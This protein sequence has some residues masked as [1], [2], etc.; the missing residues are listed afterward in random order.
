MDK[1]VSKV[2]L[3]SFSP[4]RRDPRVMRQ[5]RLLE[6]MSELTVVGFGEAPDARADFVPIHKS[7][8]PLLRKLAWGLKLLF[9][10]HE[11][12]YW[13]QP[14]VAQ[15]LETLQSAQ[16]DIIIAN[17]LSALPLALRLARGKPVIFDAHEYA[18]GEHDNEI[19][20]RL[21]LGRFNRTFC[22]RYLPQAT[23]MLTVCKGIADEYAKHYGVRPL[24][25][26]NAPAFQD[27]TPSPLEEGRIR[28]IHHGVASSARH[29]EVM[30]DMM[31]YLD[32]R[33]SLDFMLMESEPGYLAKLRDRAS[34][35]KRIRFL[36]PV[37]MPEICNR[38]NRYDLGVYLLPPDNFNHR[39]AL[40]N[41]FFEFVQARLAVAIGP[42]PEM[43]DLIGRYGCGIVSDS[44][45]PMDLAKCLSALDP[46]ELNRMKMAADKAA[47]DL[48]FENEGLVLAA[49]V[50]RL[51]P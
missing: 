28:M 5:V 16:A 3:I 44:F 45:D 46:L 51:A 9:G 10:A 48:C 21:T 24:V 17:D 49:E 39:H 30:I 37:A 47:H 1:A 42:S 22:R 18:P 26:H 14:H 33:F 36:D 32:E 31:T 27:L 38:I 25:L 7:P 2:L 43:A 41:K 11:S 40:P 12:F 23:S 6:A 13:S 15:A 20:W 50:K 8:S 29:L 35:D 4:I 19:F 34:A